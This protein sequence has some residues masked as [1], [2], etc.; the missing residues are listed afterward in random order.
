MQLRLQAQPAHLNACRII[1]GGALPSLANEVMSCALRTPHDAGFQLLTVESNIAD[2]AGRLLATGG[3]T[4]II[5]TQER[6]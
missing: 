1:R 5:Q 3:F 2:A 4:F 6:A